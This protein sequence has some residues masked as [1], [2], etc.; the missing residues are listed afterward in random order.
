MSEPFGLNTVVNPVWK[1]PM[2]VVIDPSVCTWCG[3]ALSFLSHGCT[4]LCVSAFVGLFVSV[5]A[6]CAD[7]LGCIEV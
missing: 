2:C 6:D 1:C 7:A 4:Y 5:G 3:Y